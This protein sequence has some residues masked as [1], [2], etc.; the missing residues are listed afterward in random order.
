M[1]RSCERGFIDASPIYRHL[2]TLNHVFEKLAVEELE[3]ALN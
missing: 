2:S 3:R 1:E